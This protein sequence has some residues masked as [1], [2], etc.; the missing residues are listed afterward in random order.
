MTRKIGNESK[1]LREIISTYPLEDGEGVGVTVTVTVGIGVGCG[2]GGTRESRGS[3]EG[4]EITTA[5]TP[6]VEKFV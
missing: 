2:L 5:T 1:N 6:R 3:A 4:D